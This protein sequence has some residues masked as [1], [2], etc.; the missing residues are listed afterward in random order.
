MPYIKKKHFIPVFP[1]QCQKSQLF[2]F[3]R[4]KS[5]EYLH[6]NFY[7]P[8]WDKLQRRGTDLA[9]NNNLS[10]CLLLLLF[11][12][13]LVFSF[14]CPSK[15]IKLSLYSKTRNMQFP[16]GLVARILGFPCHGLGL[17]PGGGNW[18]PPTHAANKQIVLKKKK[19]TKLGWEESSCGREICIPMADLCCCMAETNNTVKQLSSN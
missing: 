8:S 16:G 17:I 3:L 13:V 12:L 1:T 10:L 18:D 19:K 2:L 14:P 11:Y 5:M 9:G 15:P 4:A 6:L 7:Q